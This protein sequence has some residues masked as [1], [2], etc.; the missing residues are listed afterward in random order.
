MSKL[1]TLAAGALACGIVV[2]MA[3]PANAASW[4]CTA[5]N[6]RGATFSAQAIGVF[7]VAVRQRAVNQALNVCF[8]N[9]VIKQSCVIINCNRTG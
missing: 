3:A 7:S 9:T 8:A 5:R 6:A 1:R 2:A 4:L